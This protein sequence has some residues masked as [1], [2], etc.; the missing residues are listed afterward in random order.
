M[1]DCVGFVFDADRQPFIDYR[2]N[3]YIPIL[4]SD[5]H[6]FRIWGFEPVFCEQQLEKITAQGMECFVNM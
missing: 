2:Q 1:L 6:R 4:P 3:I 5:L